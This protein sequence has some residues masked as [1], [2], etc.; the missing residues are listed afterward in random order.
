MSSEEERQFLNNLLASYILDI[1]V[2]N[3]YVTI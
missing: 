1:Q 2:M 3:A